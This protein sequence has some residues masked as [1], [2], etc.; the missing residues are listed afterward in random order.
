MWIVCAAG[1]AAES[2]LADSRFCAG[3]AVR[4]HMPM[5][6]IAAFFD[7]DRTLVSCSTGPLYVKYMRSLGELPLVALFESVGFMLRYK[8][9]VLDIDR[10]M[11]ASLKRLAGR[12]AKAF[13]ALC[14]QFVDDVVVPH[15][16]PGARYVIAA[17]Q[18]V[19]HNVILLSGSLQPVVERVAYH[20][21]V[22]HAVG[23][24]LHTDGAVL[25][26]DY[27]RPPCFGQGK[28]HYAQGLAAELGFAVEKSY[29]YTDSYTD[30]PLLERVAAPRV[31]APDLRL[32]WAAGRRGWPVVA[33]PD[34]SA[35][36][37]VTHG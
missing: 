28:V 21:E 9:S 8:L 24:R 35:L 14:Y 16:V 13:N 27:E 3:A 4:Y 36:R 10:M 17:H 33:F 34:G 15:L 7:L 11:A 25:S 31:V 6:A 2:P 29:F 37:H 1:C 22:A 23:S 18:G 30:M 12:D 19:E 20:L 5:S 32:R 26:G